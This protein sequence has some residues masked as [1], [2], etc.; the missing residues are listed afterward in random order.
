LNKVY[1]PFIDLQSFDLTD[2]NIFTRR[3]EIIVI[4]II[5]IIILMKG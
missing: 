2:R 1:I 3:L 4:I 5:I